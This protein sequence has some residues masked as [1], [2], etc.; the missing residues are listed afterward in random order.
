MPAKDELAANLGEECGPLFIS[1][2]ASYA[3][4]VAGSGR[5]H[6]VW[7]TV[8]LACLVAPPWGGA[9][10]AGLWYR[11]RAWAGRAR[12][13]APTGLPANPAGLAPGQR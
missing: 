9:A 6:A 5:A 13:A 11:E 10:R 7:G 12:G 1:S 2:L 3:C 8:T 4:P